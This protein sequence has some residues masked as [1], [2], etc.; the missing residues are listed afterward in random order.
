MLLPYAP[1]PPVMIL[2]SAIC[3]Y[4][5][6]IKSAHLLYD[7]VT[8]VSSPLTRHILLFSASMLY[9]FL[10]SPSVEVLIWFK[11]SSED[12]FSVEA[13]MVRHPSSSERISPSFLLPFYMLKFPFCECKSFCLISHCPHYLP[14]ACMLLQI[15]SSSETAPD[16]SAQ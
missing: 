12:I 2:L 7:A 10:P 16:I 6:H 5:C 11:C 8:M 15:R 9:P 14:A 1:P 13:S 4:S 3:Q